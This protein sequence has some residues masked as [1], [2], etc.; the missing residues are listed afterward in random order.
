MPLYQFDCKQCDEVVERICR[1][2]E[3]DNQVCPNCGTKVE[4]RLSATENVKFEG[5]Q[6]T[7]TMKIQR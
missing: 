4:K 3:I 7:S 6:A 1:Y 5:V 2:S